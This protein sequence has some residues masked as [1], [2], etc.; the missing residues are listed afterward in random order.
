MDFTGTD[1][2]IIEIPQNAQ[3]AAARK[4]VLSAEPK[5]TQSD[6]LNMTPAQQQDI[7][8]QIL[9]I[10]AIQTEFLK[11]DAAYDAAYDRA[12]NPAALCV[13]KFGAGYQFGGRVESQS[14]GGFVVNAGY[15]CI[16]EGPSKR[17][18]YEKFVINV[19]GYLSSIGYRLHH[20]L[21]RI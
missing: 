12:A 11:R 13:K 7:A 20:P 19:T 2:Q 3:R 9:E 15:M 17:T 18:T 14:E 1:I 5:I 4:A 16:K 8:M 6:W 21:T 10:R